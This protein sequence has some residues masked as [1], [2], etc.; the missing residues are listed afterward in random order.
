[1]IILFLSVVKSGRG[2]F[3]SFFSR[4]KE[5]RG[6]GL[7]AQVLCSGTPGGGAGRAGAVSVESREAP[8]IQLRDVHIMLLLSEPLLAK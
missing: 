3:I 1:M 7:H 6:L 2:Y 8:G 5:M 4:V